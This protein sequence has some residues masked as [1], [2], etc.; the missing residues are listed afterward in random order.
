VQVTNAAQNFQMLMPKITGTSITVSALVGTTPSGPFSV[1]HLDGLTPGQTGVQLT[2]PAPV[3]PVSPPP[4]TSNVGAN[5]MF[6]W[7]SSP[8]VAFF[9]LY[10]DGVQ[11]DEGP[12]R[13]F[14]ITEDYKTQLPVFGGPS[15]IPLPKARQCGW[16]IEIHGLYA[17]V[18][19]ATG[20]TGFL[21]SHGYYYYGELWG[22]KR[23]NGGFSTSLT[24][25]L[26]TAP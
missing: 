19:Q 14:V 13:F 21:D 6:Q 10:C 2:V 7:S 12:T 24:Y 23:D 15:G 3:S 22:L 1:A 25:Y 9:Y 5:S 26:T 11:T 17:T 16:S 18:D 8:K 20:P 4:G